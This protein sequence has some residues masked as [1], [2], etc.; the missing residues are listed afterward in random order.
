MLYR[1]VSISFSLAFHNTN[2]QTGCSNVSYANEGILLKTASLDH[3]SSQLAL[4]FIYNS[5]N[6]HAVLPMVEFLSNE[7]VKLTYSEKNTTV[8]RNF[9]SG[10]TNISVSVINSELA[11]KRVRFEWEQMVQINSSHCKT[12]SLSNVK[13]SLYH[14]RCTRNLFYN[15]Y[16][17]KKLNLLF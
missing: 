11:D 5:N 16:R 7:R 14:G 13:I 1:S 10:V 8:P 12:W 3:E 2:Q 17:Y 6:I 15:D 9:I 4:K